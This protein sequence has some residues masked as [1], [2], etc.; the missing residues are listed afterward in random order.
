[1]RKMKEY[2]DILQQDSPDIEYHMKYPQKSHFT[3]KIDSWYNKMYAKYKKNKA[4][5]V[6]AEKVEC[7]F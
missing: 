7:P 3:P 1:M 6:K 4:A 2:N 5:Y